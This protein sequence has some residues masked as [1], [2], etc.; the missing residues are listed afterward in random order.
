MIA[1]EELYRDEHVVAVAKPSGLSVHRGLDRSEDTVVDRLRAQG[2]DAHPVHR[3]DRATSGVLLCARTKAAAVA[4][5][6]AFQQG[7]V[8]KRYL[9]LVRGV[10]PER[11]LV[12]HAIPV[13]EGGPRA[14]AQTLVRRLEHVTLASS[15]LREKR[16]SLVEAQ[17]LTGRFH[18]VRRHL[19]HLSL[20]V[21]GDTTYGKSEHNRFC[22]RAFGLQRLA[23]HAATVSLVACEGLLPLQIRCPIPE[24]LRI[25]ARRMG[26]CS[27]E[28]G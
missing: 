25:A 17:P 6:A 18:Q 14:A 9:S 24:D 19:K 8:T 12:D 11:E 10:A 22:A 23:L 21:L 3:L 1:L 4:L 28:L 13:D 20:P 15:P 2:L 7:G 16:Y 27:T 26:F 5:G